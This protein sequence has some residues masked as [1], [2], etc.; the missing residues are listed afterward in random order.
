MKDVVNNCYDFLN[1]LFSSRGDIVIKELQQKDHVSEWDEPNSR[2]EYS[3]LP[4]E[5]S[6][7]KKHEE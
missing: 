4:L 6:D 7:P 2:G 3:V 5:F 1:H